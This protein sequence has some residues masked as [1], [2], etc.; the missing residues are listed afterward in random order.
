MPLTVHLN[1]EPGRAVYQLWT[2]AAGSGVEVPPTGVVNFASSDPTVATVDATGLLAYLKEGTTTITADDG[3]S[4]P[5]SDV[6]TVT[7]AV[8]VSS[9]LTLVSGVPVVTPLRTSK[10]RKG[11]PIAS[12]KPA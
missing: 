6:L 9:T 11:G 5:A 10:K 7:A 4:L 1:E 3:G 12:A 2:G 8:A